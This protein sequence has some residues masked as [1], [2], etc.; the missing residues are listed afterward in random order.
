MEGKDTLKYTLKF[1]FIALALPLQLATLSYGQATINGPGAL[2]FVS[3]FRDGVGTT[4]HNAFLSA[5][6]RDTPVSALHL[7]FARPATEKRL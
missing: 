5:N 7:R 3:R 6:V 1:R 2:S 4:Q